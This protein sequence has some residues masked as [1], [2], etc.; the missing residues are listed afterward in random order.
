MRLPTTART[1][2][3]ET[4]SRHRRSRRRRRQ[5]LGAHLR[6]GREAQGLR[7]AGIAASAIAA[8]PSALGVDGAAID[9]G[10]QPPQPVVSALRLLQHAVR[11]RSSPRNR[12]RWGA[13]PARP[14]GVAAV[15]EVRRRSRRSSAAPE[16]R[17]RRG[18]SYP[19]F[20]KQ[21]TFDF[22]LRHAGVGRWWR[23][24][25]RG[26]RLLSP[27][28][29]VMRSLSA[30]RQPPVAVQRTSDCRRGKKP[31]RHEVRHRLQPPRRNLER[32][33]VVP[34]RGG[35]RRTPVRRHQPR[36]GV[37]DIRPPFCGRR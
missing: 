31:R 12:R 7:T 8:W 28:T 32:R 36:L 5:R 23:R 27:S 33:M 20:L 15:V 30:Q 13:D 6:R 35:R 10:L 34:C 26:R 29:K 24:P 17:C 1:D 14:R 9:R 4:V 21:A 25:R 22:R 37:A 2:Q 19:S 18:S 3:P 16:R 11:V